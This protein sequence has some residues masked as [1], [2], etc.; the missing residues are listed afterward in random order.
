MLRNYL[1]IAIRN[2]MRRKAYAFINVG[3]LAAGLACCM[4]I[5]LYV[6]NESSY[7]QYHR[8]GD[9]LYRVLEYRKVPALEFCTARISAMVATILR[10]YE[11]DVEQ[12][13]SVFPV[14]NALVKRDNVTAFEDRVVYSE[15]EFFN[16][17]TIPFLRG[18]QYILII[19]DNGVGIQ[20]NANIKSPQ[21]LGFQLINGLVDQIRGSIEF[22]GRDGTSFKI[23]FKV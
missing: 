19:S 18:N 15:S 2:L 20:E 11:N 16:V 21:T 22:D 4:V 5:L 13:A 12:I 3:G 6:S 23:I 8:D 10:E 17:L 14:S 9:R 1:K 7:D